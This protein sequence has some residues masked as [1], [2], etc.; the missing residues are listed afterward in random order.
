MKVPLS[1]FFPN[2]VVSLCCLLSRDLKYLHC[3]LKNSPSPY[4][5]DS[6]CIE[7][8]KSQI[9][10]SWLLSQIIIVRENSSFSS[11]AARLE[12]L[13]QMLNDNWGSCIRILD[14]GI[15]VV[16]RDDCDSTGQENFSGLIFFVEIVA[17]LTNRRIERR[18]NMIPFQIFF[19]TA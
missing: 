3:G 7:K 11:I 1:L 19:W 4:N 17:K 15:S 2:P 18:L 12:V 10:S 8:Q 6:Y 5:C 9:V 14:F 13:P 16:A